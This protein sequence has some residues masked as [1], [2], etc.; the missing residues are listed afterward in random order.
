MP[1]GMKL[2]V[3]DNPLSIPGT[4]SGTAVWVRKTK[5]SLHDMLEGA[6]TTWD[7]ECLDAARVVTETK[8]LST[9]EMVAFLTTC[10]ADNLV[11][12]I[13]DANQVLHLILRPLVQIDMA[14]SHIEYFKRD[15]LYLHI[16]E[17]FVRDLN[18]YMPEQ[19]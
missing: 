5:I 19:T 16:L 17:S 7:V 8:C 2:V 6:Q 18:M 3:S 11:V 4:F 10:K 1:Y 13:N 14:R 12:S 9:K 15:A